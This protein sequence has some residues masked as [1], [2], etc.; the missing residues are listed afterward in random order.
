MPYGVTTDSSTKHHV[1]ND[2]LT[3]FDKT[4]VLSLQ[5]NEFYNVMKFFWSSLQNVKIVFMK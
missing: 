3:P 4:T 2:E 1:Y 5:K